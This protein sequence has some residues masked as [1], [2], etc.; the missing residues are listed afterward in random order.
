MK[1]SA[2]LACIE[3]P[4]FMDELTDALA[5]TGATVAFDAIGGGSIAGQILAAMEAAGVR[6]S[7]S[8]EPRRAPRRSRS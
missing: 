1:S 6:V 7:P 2:V 3:S 5:T 8:L 4:A